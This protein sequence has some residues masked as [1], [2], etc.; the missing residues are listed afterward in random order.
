[1]DCRHGKTAPEGPSGPGRRASLNS[2]R[3]H[4]LQ[5]LVV[6]VVETLR[7]ALEGL[8]D[9]V[10]FLLHGGEGRRRDGA[11]ETEMSGRG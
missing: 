5:R 6:V 8:L 7:E 11:K 2:G 3:L 4:P 1:M 9:A 10:A